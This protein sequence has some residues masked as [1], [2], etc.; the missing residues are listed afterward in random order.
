MAGWGIDFLKN[1]GCY[2][3]SPGQEGGLRADPSAAELYQR[4]QDA[5][6]STGRPIVHNVKGIPG[7]GCS[8]EVARQVS[9]M[10]RCGDD[11]GD[12]FGAAV[13]EF[14]NCQQFQQVAG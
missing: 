13:G 2:T 11:I 1:D 7:G 12:F 10:R 9:N 8:I 4:V 5:I 14:G 6:R 3:A